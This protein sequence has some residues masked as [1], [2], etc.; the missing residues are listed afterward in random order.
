MADD[1]NGIRAF[2]VPVAVIQMQLVHG[3]EARLVHLVLVKDG[4]GVV[5]AVVVER[6]PQVDGLAGMVDHLV[7]QQQVF[8]DIDNGLAGRVLQE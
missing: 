8:P 1:G 3:A 5:L 4:S 6:D 2:A 7:N